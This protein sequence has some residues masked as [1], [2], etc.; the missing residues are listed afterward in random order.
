[1]SERQRA[2]D[3]IPQII[4]DLYALVGKLEQLFP[5][6]RFTPDGHLI[7]S[8]GEVVAA[9]RYN[10]QLL[11]ASAECHDATSESG[12]RV[13][14]KATQVR[15]VGLR[16]EPEHLLVLKI[17]KHGHTSEAFNGPGFLA[18]RAAGRMQKNGQ[19]PISI[20][21]LQELMQEVPADARIQPIS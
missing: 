14:I 8:I 11:P 21:K 17:S 18:W 13:Q 12:I 9:H 5:S 16:A 1:M 4:E 19:R 2:L 3:A 6:R 15:S 7:G 10:L 20:S